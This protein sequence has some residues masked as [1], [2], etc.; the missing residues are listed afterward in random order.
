[1]KRNCFNYALAFVIFGLFCSSFTFAQ[2]QLFISETGND[3]NSGTIQQPLAT[4]T[5]ARNKARQT[6]AKTIFIRGGRYYFDETCFLGSQDSGITFSG[7]ND[8]LVIFDGSKFIDPKGFKTVTTPSVLNRLNPRASGNVKAL[9]RFPNIGFGHISKNGLNTGVE[10]ANTKGTLNNPKGAKFKMVESING[11]KWNEELRTNKRAQIKGY[12][13]A[14]WLKETNQIHSVSASGEIRFVNGT[15]YGLEKR[16][17]AIMRFFIYN[18]LYELDEPGEWF[19]DTA[20]TTLYVWFDGAI[21]KNTTIGAWA[22]PQLFEIR[23]ARNVTIQKMTV[24]NLGKQEGGGKG[25]VNIIGQSENI[26]VAGVRF[27]FIAEHMTAFNIWHDVK[28]SSILSC[29]IYE[30]KERL[31]V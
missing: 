24:Q 31:L 19:F 27:R 22:G 2:N 7:Y 12:L 26:L 11:R 29:D 28:N 1:M 18:L 8:E 9:K 13:S 25:A 10:T 20:D 21:D 30:E 14:D 17:D 4:L 5:G 15:R 6:G 16:R 3:N 23:D